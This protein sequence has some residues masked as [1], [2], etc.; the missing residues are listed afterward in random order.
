MALSKDSRK[1]Y[2]IAQIPEPTIVE[3][4][5]PEMFVSKE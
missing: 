4:D 5:L 1:L 3:F 2:G